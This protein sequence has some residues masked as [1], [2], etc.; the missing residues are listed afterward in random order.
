MFHRGRIVFDVAGA[1]RAAT[2][3]ADLLS[4]FKRDQGEELSDDA[5]LLD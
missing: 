4:L 1:E 3:V 5:L 2:S